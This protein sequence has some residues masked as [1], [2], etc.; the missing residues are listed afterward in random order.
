[1][2]WDA[3]L[4]KYTQDEEYIKSCNPSHAIPPIQGQCLPHI[5]AGLSLI[6]EGRGGQIVFSSRLK[7]ILMVYVFPLG[8]LPPLTLNSSCNNIFTSVF[9][10]SFF[11]NYYR[12]IK[13]FILL[14][15]AFPN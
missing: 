8:L 7:K 15:K 5:W 14:S 4:H 1:M 3:H 12:S 11:R 6:Q 9:L 2:Y 13:K 10:F